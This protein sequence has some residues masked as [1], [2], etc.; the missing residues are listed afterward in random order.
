MPGEPEQRARRRRRGRDERR[1]SRRDRPR[2]HAAL[3]ELVGIAAV[4]PDGL[5]VTT[6]GVYVRV[7]ECRR[8]PNVISAGSTT[9]AQIENAWRQ[10]CHEIPDLQGLSFY[11]QRD[12]LDLDAALEPDVAR[13]KL[14]VDQDRAHDRAE[15]ARVR[16]RLFTGQRQSVA[17]AAGGAQPAVEERFYVAVPHTPELSIQERARKALRPPAPTVH[18]TWEGHDLAAHESAARAGE[19]WHRLRGMDTDPRL[20][21]AVEV[22]AI[23]WERLHP[24][25][26]ALP[27]FDRLARVPRIV[28]ATDREAAA[29]H[30]REIMEAVSAGGAVEMDPSDPRWLL[31]ADGTR[32]ETLVLGTT[33]LQTSPAWLAHLMQVPVSSTLAV[34]IRVGSR[35]LMRGRQHRHHARLAAAVSYKERR[36]KTVRPE[37]EDAREEAAELSAEL[38]ASNTAAVYDVTVA[39]SFRHGDPDQLDALMRAAAKAFRGATDAKVLRGRLLGVRGFASTLPLGRDALGTT[40]RYA[41]RNIAHMVPIN[42]ASCGFRDGLVLGTSALGGTLERLHPYDQLCRNAVTLVAGPSGSGKTVAVNVML[43][44]AIA[45][46]MPGFIIDQSSTRAE[47]GRSRVQGHYDTLVSLI[48]GSRRVTVGVAGGDVVNPWDVPDVGDVPNHKLTFLRELHTLLIGDKINDDDRRLTSLDEG[49]LT[50][51]IAG[52]YARC[53]QTG[54]M[55]RETLLIDQF[56]DTATRHPDALIASALHSLIARLEPFC[57]GGPFAFIADE[58][59][60][61]QQGAPLT[62]FDLAGCSKTF[63]PALIL[64]LVDHIE[65]VVQTHR[66][67]YVAGREHE[68]GPWAGRMFLVIDEGW[69]L[70]RSKGTGEWLHEYAKRARHFELWLVFI[71]QQFSDLDT[72]QG[73]ALLD[74]RSIALCFCNDAEDLDVA[75]SPLG[76]TD[77]DIATI[78]DLQTAKGEYSEVFLLSPRGRGV[79]RIQLGDVE[80]WTASSDPDRDQPVRAAALADAGG[81]PWEALRLL[82][83]PEWQD[84]YHA[85]VTR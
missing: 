15:L 69:R 11:V 8:P 37:E 74:N 44:R 63:A 65:H 33:P 22:L 57:E 36:S 28:Q 71:S 14:A 51:A 68:L 17:R 4:E 77:T 20:L 16:M 38:A 67:R 27:D 79:V 75:R 85:P 24:A 12:P 70:T 7:I 34:H 59:T 50:T 56:R 82:C 52:V 32:E 55:P 78:G 18:A 25:A 81:D 46:G 23:V 35:E 61:V 41:S 5:L 66:A 26:D 47:D 43:S 49:L 30:C 21:D 29:A 72:P 58:P 10:L 76:L 13:V 60:T 53:A 31:H 3:D 62:L 54:E 80:Y 42:T 48:P 6:E 2:H 9:L 84:S 45:Q 83:S 64:T 19:V 40:R 39:A 73:R 1:T